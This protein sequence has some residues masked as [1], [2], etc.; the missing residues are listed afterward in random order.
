MPF[1]PET[2]LL[3]AVRWL[4]ELRDSNRKHA[5]E[6][7]RSSPTYAGITP[8]QYAAAFEWL[9]TTELLSVE[10]LHQMSDQLLRKMVLRAAILSAR[11]AWLPD[12]DLLIRSNT[13]LPEDVALAAEALGVSVSDCLKEIGDCRGR[14]DL[15]ARSRL[16]RAGEVAFLE[17]LQTATDGIVVHVASFDDSFGYDVF[18]E[19]SE[20]ASAFEVKTTNRKGRLTIYLSRNEY[21]V[22][23]SDVRWN[24]VVVQLDE[25]D[26]I[27]AIATVSTAWLHSNVPVD[28]SP[29][30]RWESVSLSPPWDALTPGVPA[31]VTDSSKGVPSQ[32]LRRGLADVSGAPA[33]MPATVVDV[34]D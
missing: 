7:L 8:T 28:I 31:H 3:A 23:R 12:A 30:S 29:A 25:S 26:Y 14:I 15:E 18:W 6:V 27:N 9:K 19:N 1:P 11:P 5:Y 33:W 21:E 10:N 2:L 22:S 32:L 34:C 17:L 24:L 4:H 13:D 20:H 16:G